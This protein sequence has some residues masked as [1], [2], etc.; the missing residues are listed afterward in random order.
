MMGHGSVLSHWSWSCLLQMSKP[1]S[2]YDA[3]HAR[4]AWDC[5]YMF[6]PGRIRAPNRS[7]NPQH[8]EGLWCLEPTP[9]LSRILAIRIAKFPGEIRLFTSNDPIT[10]H[11]QG[12]Y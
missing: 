9:N 7:L 12:G 8:I 6:P 11:H 2:S 3:A 10:E 4:N 5:S 1:P